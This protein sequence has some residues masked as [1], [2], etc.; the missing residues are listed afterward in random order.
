[1]AFLAGSKAVLWARLYIRLRARMERKWPPSG[2]RIEAVAERAGRAGRSIGTSMQHGL[3]GLVQIRKVD[4]LVLT[5]LEDDVAQHLATARALAFD[6]DHEGGALALLAQDRAQAEHRVDV[7]RRDRHARY[8]GVRTIWF[9]GL[10]FRI[11][12]DE[13]E[14][15]L[16]V[17]RRSQRRQRDE[18][19][20]ACCKLD[21]LKLDQ[22]K[23]DHLAPPG[24]TIA[25]D[26]RE[27]Q[28]CR[29]KGQ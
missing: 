10:I 7:A 14:V 11:G 5:R 16:P 28:E 24:E 27:C 23:L 19:Q 2:P 6:M 9:A 12:A 13:R 22:L 26:F 15:V 8:A 3:V 4:G 20:H 25:D 1:M 18:A 21:R 29:G 17:H